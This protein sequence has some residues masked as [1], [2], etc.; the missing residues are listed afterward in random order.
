MLAQSLWSQE[1]TSKSQNLRKQQ[2]PLLNCLERGGREGVICP[3]SVVCE[4]PEGHCRFTTTVKCLLEQLLPVQPQAPLSKLRTAEKSAHHRLP[5]LQRLPGSLSHPSGLALGHSLH[6]LPISQGGM[7]GLQGGQQ[8]AGGSLAHQ[9]Q[10]L[11]TH[12]VSRISAFK[13]IQHLTFS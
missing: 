13:C 2:D 8:E 12:W 5:S 10:S 9:R 1:G 6:V 4:V 11:L 3:R 7:S